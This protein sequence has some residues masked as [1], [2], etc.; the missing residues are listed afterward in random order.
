MFTPLRIRVFFSQALIWIVLILLPMNTA[1]YLLRTASSGDTVRWWESCIQYSIHE[2]GYPGIAPETLRETLRA[3]FDTWEDVTCSFFYFEETAPA[4]CDDIGYA[5]ESG[6]MNLL[7]F[8][9]EGW[10]NDD[11]HGRSDVALTTTSWD[12]SS[13]RLLNADIEFNADFFDF[14]T[15]GRPD[16]FDLQNT[17]THEIGHVLGLDESPVVDSTMFGSASAAETDKRTLEADDIAAVCSLYPTEEDPFVCLAPHCGLDLTCS[18]T[19][20][21]APGIANPPSEAESCSTS[22]VALSARDSFLAK[23]TRFLL[24]F[25]W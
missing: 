13:G 16:T 10:L 20:C 7:V 12:D 23:V 3:S 22:A 21:S 2:S 24:A 14:S 4:A 15:D 25:A 17:A 19:D 18:S 1:A 5:R 6:N 11:A 9:T 8:K